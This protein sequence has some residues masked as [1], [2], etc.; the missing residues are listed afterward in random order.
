MPLVGVPKLQHLCVTLLLEFRDCLEDIGDTPIELLQP[1][2]T[3]CNAEQLAGIEE[4][5]REGGR[6]LH[7]ALQPHWHRV[8]VADFGDWQKLPSLQGVQSTS[9]L[10]N[11]ARLSRNW[12]Q[13]YEIS[14]ERLR[15]KAAGLG[16]RLRAMTQ[17][18][19]QSRQTKHVEIIEAPRS[20][21]RPGSS[22]RTGAPKQHI[23]VVPA[24]QRVLAKL[25]LLHNSSLKHLVQIRPPKRATPQFSS[26]ALRQ[27]TP[28][29]PARASA[30]MHKLPNKQHAGLK[31]SISHGR[32][33]SSC[34]TDKER[35][36]VKP[37]KTFKNSSMLMQKPAVT[38]ESEAAAT[39]GA[40]VEDEIDWVNPGV[41]PVTNVPSMPAKQPWTVH[42]LEDCGNDDDEGSVSKLGR[43]KACDSQAG[44]RLLD[45]APV[46]HG[47]AAWVEDD[48]QWD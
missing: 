16:K 28:Q 17:A 7:D 37:S 14:Q 21:K 22:N 34:P 5:T 23:Q 27:R 13:L 39:S 44:T 2:L 4:G 32:G 36:S 47:T 9:D 43:R 40:L 41:L 11:G 29:M 38:H 25:G 18:E 42:F 26:G 12:R 48:I 33:F 31:H 10:H 8:L 6:E 3:R 45:I 24:R 30:G 20:L 35:Y 19:V 15:Q 46:K 1:V